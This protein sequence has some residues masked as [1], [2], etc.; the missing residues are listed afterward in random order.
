MKKSIT[1]SLAIF[2]ASC[3]SRHPYPRII[4]DLDANN[5]ISV[6]TPHMVNTHREIYH[7]QNRFEDS[8]GSALIAIPF[9]SVPPKPDLKVIIDTTY[10]FSSKGFEYNRIDFPLKGDERFGSAREMENSVQIRRWS[11]L[12]D[13]L[14][15]QFVEA[16]AVLIKNLSK[17]NALITNYKIIQEALDSDRQWKP[18]EF[19]SNVPHDVHD[20]TKEAIVLLP[21]RYLGRAAIKY[22]G[23]FKTKIRVKCRIN[24][25][26]V[27]YSNAIDGN[28]NRNQFKTDFLKSYV[29]YNTNFTEGDL[30]FIGYVFLDKY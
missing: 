28:I 7:L 23:G 17:T 18:I 6:N 22:E 20:G 24:D 19:Y 10:I 2:F 9:K 27:F 15:K 14:P 25:Q 21:N 8:L 11:K 4:E 5:V 16:R 1:V 30:D 12:K 29:R 26:Y 3:E 13:S